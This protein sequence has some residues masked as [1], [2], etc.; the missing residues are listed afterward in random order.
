MEEVCVCVRAERRKDAW[1]VEAA[2]GV[3][4][5]V[6]E[7]AEET[8]DLTSLF[9]RS[10]IQPCSPSQELCFVFLDTEI[11][12]NMQLDFKISSSDGESKPLLQNLQQLLF[13]RNT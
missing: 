11:P 10:I 12:F 1:T 7:G 8:L 5:D 3:R 2:K 6:L 9:L 4:F 13:T